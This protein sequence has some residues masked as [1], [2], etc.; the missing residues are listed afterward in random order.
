MSALLYAACLTLAATVQNNAQ[1]NENVSLAE[2]EASNL[3]IDFKP[4]RP[5]WYATQEAGG[6][7]QVVGE[8]IFKNRTEQAQE[9]QTVSLE[10]L[11]ENGSRIYR[12]DY[13]AADL[14]Q[15]MI[16]FSRNAG[17]GADEA[18]P[19]PPGIT[20]I[21]AGDQGIIF[22]TNTNATEQRPFVARIALHFL[23]AQKI[24]TSVPVAEFAAA[25]RFEPPFSYETDKYW[26]ATNT[27]GQYHHWYGILP[28][29]EN[30][31]ISQRYATDFI[32]LNNKGEPA[33]P[34]GSRR[35]EDYFA[36]GKN[37]LSASD[38]KIVA[39][40][41]NLPD[42]E[43]GQT[44][45]KNP[46]GNYVVIQHAP[47]LYS[48]YGHLQKNSIVVQSGDRVAKNQLLGKV[49]NSGNTSLP[50]LHFHIMDAWDG[51]DSVKSVFRSQGLPALFWNAKVYRGGNILNLNGRSL[52]ELDG[53]IP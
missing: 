48:F 28:E 18:V 19:K 15:M 41:N 27:A 35:K 10:L 30:Y 6:K 32:K 50:H 47:N 22:I 1:S 9:I 7:W 33:A 13:D 40:V 4:V 12:K 51:K 53:I 24:E 25:K 29:G 39:V 45:A 16:V 17:G 23:V 38:G 43:I 14:R 34:T 20:K 26:I 42:Q 36:W 49:G 3:R 11:A 2:T 21:A 46:G 52:S 8:S 44:D 31:F 5:L 37:V